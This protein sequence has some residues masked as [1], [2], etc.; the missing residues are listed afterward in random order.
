MDF[1]AAPGCGIDLLIA[2]Q[3]PNERALVQLLG[4]VGRYGQEC[5]RWKL[6]EVDPL[7]NEAQARKLRHKV[8]Q[9]K[10]KLQQ[11]DK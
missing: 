10:E 8:R 5:S 6:Q 2:T 3:L 1:R 9:M 11:E 4:R 7:V